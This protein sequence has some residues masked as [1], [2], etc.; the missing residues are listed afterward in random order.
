VVGL[1]DTG[2]DAEEPPPQAASSMIR[3]VA[4][5]TLAPCAAKRLTLNIPAP[6]L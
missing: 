6:R 5:I 1:V 4:P 2:G 3:V